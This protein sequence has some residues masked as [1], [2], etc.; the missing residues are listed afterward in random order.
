VEEWGW[1]GGGG[2]RSEWEAMTFPD[3]SH[4][5]KRKTPQDCVCPRNQTVYGP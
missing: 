3:P 1:K 5:V 2:E 4:C